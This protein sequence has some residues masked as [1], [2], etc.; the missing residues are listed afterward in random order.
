MGKWIPTLKG[1]IDVLTFHAQP[2]LKIK[3]YNSFFKLV[4]T[5]STTKIFI[6]Y[7]RKTKY[8]T[9]NIAVKKTGGN[10]RKW[11]NIVRQVGRKYA[12]K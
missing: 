3:S 8:A 1:R 10:L 2:Y 11:R 7:I 12:K 6:D 5:V 4:D 9:K